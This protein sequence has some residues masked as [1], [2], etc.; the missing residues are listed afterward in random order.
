MIDELDFVV[1]GDGEINFSE[2]L[3]ATLDVRSFF[4]E[5]KLRAVF[6]I[7]DTENKGKIDE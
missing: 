4:K 1:G 7:F 6:A 5:A 3:A 2:F